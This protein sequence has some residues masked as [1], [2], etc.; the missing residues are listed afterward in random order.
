MTC[1]RCGGPIGRQVGPGGRRRYCQRC[2]PPRDRK[3]RPRKRPLR[4]V[5]LPTDGQVSPDGV[6]GMTGATRRELQALGFDE[7]HWLA[8]LA[9]NLARHIDHADGE[10]VAG[11]I[12]MIREHDACLSDIRARCARSAA[13]P[14]TP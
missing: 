14:H 4:P 13:L 3:D 1:S 9:L 10:P 2:S 12:A 5:A 6:V 11:L 7:G 8:I